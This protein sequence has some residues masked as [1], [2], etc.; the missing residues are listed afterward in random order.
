M[1]I[2]QVQISLNDTTLE[3]FASIQANLC[4]RSKR[5]IYLSTFNIKEL[6]AQCL[7]ICGSITHDF[8][9]KPASKYAR[10]FFTLELVRAYLTP[11]WEDFDNIKKFNIS[12]IIF[13]IQNVKSIIVSK[14]Y[15][16]PK[17]GCC[18]TVTKYTTTRLGNLKF[19]LSFLGRTLSRAFLYLLMLCLYKKHVYIQQLPPVGQRFS[20]AD[21]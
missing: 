8:L 18:M 1:Q 17:F 16:Y 21:T 10:N 19:V 4:L 14:R 12:G 11:L 15:S 6:Q 2:E 13:S 7:A 3:E 5:Q 20:S 9:R